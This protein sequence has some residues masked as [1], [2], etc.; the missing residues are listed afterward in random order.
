M[1]GLPP[2]HH[3]KQAHRQGIIPRKTNAPPSTLLGKSIR[4]H[5]R[6]GNLAVTVKASWST[7]RRAAPSL[8]PRS[9]RRSPNRL[10][11]PNT[12]WKQITALQQS[13]NSPIASVWQPST[14]MAT[15][16]RD[17]HRHPW[18]QAFPAGPTAILRA[19]QALL[20]ITARHG[21][22]LAAVRVNVTVSLAEVI[23]S[24][25]TVEVH[26]AVTVT[27]LVLVALPVPRRNTSLAVLDGMA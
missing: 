26:D 20:A 9:S 3:P 7:F 27:I 1:I 22:V 13:R 10:T 18:D 12:F 21:Q 2:S 25:S 17:L 15:I 11:R 5:P 16:W 19:Q 6:G 14:S 4:P 8:S 23:E 24:N